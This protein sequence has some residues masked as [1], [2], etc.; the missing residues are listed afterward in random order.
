M[1]VDSCCKSYPFS[2]NTVHRGAVFGESGLGRVGI[3]IAWSILTSVVGS[4]QNARHTRKGKSVGAHTKPASQPP[5]PE[6][7]RSQHERLR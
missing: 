6:K 5:L 1:L 2:R 7:V 4:N 3:V